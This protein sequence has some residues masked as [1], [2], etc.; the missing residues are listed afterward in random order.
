MLSLLLERLPC[1]G[2]VS[3]CGNPALT[4]LFDVAGLLLKQSCGGWLGGSPTQFEPLLRRLAELVV[5][6]PVVESRVSSIVDFAMAG[7]LK[8]LTTLVRILHHRFRHFRLLDCVCLGF[9]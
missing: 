4:T 9:I 1:P 3:K 7:T 8:L 6:C 5:R 2:D